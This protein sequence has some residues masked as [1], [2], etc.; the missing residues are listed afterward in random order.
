MTTLELLP[1]AT[2]LDPHEMEG[3]KLEHITTRGE[4]NRWEQENIQDAIGWL[5]RRRK[6]E[7]LSEAFVCRLHER[8]FDKVWNWAGK[9]RRTG[10]N[11]GVEWTVIPTE[12]RKLLDDVKYWIENKT[13]HPDEIAGRLHHKLVWIH[14]FM[15]GNGRHARLMTD[16]LLIEELEQPS[17]TWGGG[18]LLDTVSL[19]GRYISSLKAADR[20]DYALLLE[21]VRS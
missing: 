18:N 20:N 15:N 13:Y 3:L 9:F 11:I 21:F 5:L 12:L 17:F 14:P 7:I 10:K 4:L 19:R 1:G 6:G 8:M 16:I 2:L